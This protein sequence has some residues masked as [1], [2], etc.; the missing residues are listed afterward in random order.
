MIRVSRRRALAL[1]GGVPVSP[2][3]AAAEGAII[4]AGFVSIGG[5]DQWVTIHGQTARTR[6]ARA[7]SCWRALAV[8][9]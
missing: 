9:T 2:G 7:A 1:A 5:L 6:R 3:V 8:A 4:E